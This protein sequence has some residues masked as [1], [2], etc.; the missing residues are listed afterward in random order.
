MKISG[1]H[2]Q[3]TGSGSC[4][5]NYSSERSTFASNTNLEKRRSAVALAGYGETRVLVSELRLETREISRAAGSGT[6]ESMPREA[7]KSKVGENNF[8]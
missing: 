3:G 8:L 5:W 6:R 4:S 2:E 7:R 1:N